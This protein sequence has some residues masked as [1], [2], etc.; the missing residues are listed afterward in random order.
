MKCSGNG[1]EIHMCVKLRYSICNGS[2][3][4]E[5]IDDRRLVDMYCEIEFPYM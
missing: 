3:A 1:K 4:A 5:S 2:Y